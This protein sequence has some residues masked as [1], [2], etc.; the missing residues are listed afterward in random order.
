MEQY[1]KKDAAKALDAK[2]R[3]NK[4]FMKAQYEEALEC[5][6]ESLLF[7]PE[8][9]VDS[10]ALYHNNKAAAHFMLSEWEDVVYEATQAIYL[11]DKFT[12]A[13]LRRAKDYEKLDKL[14]EELE[15]YKVISEIDPSDK[16]SAKKVKELEKIV[17]EKFEKQKDEMLSKLKDFG[18]TI[19]GKFGMSLDQFQAVQDPVT[20]SYSVSFGNGPAK[21]DTTEAEQKK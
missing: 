13:L 19:L 5:Y 21:S 3:G 9:D 10:Q 16:F 20:G 18:N 12:K 1:L 17:A 7:V 6:A 14:S 4:F 8:E 15:D 2:E 11:K